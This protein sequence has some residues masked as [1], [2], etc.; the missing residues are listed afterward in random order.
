MGKSGSKY[1]NNTAF[2]TFIRKEKDHCETITM[3]KYCLIY[4]ILKSKAY[5]KLKYKINWPSDSPKCLLII[6]ASFLLFM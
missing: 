1:H 5:R 3:I 2:S 4:K 6:E